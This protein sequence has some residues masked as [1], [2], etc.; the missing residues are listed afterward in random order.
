MPLLR[1]QFATF[2]SPNSDAASPC[3]HIRIIFDIAVRLFCRQEQI[4]YRAIEKIDDWKASIALGASHRKKQHGEDG[5]MG[6]SA[7]PAECRLSPSLR[8]LR[9]FPRGDLP[10]PINRPHTGLDLATR[11]KSSGALSVSKC[12]R[13]RDGPPAGSERWRMCWTFCPPRLPASR[14]AW[15][16]AIARFNVRS[17]SDARTVGG[18]DGSRLTK[19]GLSPGVFCVTVTAAAQKHEPEVATMRGG[20]SRIEN[21]L[22]KTEAPSPRLLFHVRNRPASGVPAS[23]A[24]PEVNLNP[25]RTS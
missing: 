22:L 21:Q 10:R 17:K 3:R 23:G 13:D 16:S 20:E 2:Y 8:A 1:M 19:T 5:S 14:R 18:V 15:Q 9:N 25:C 24:G 7:M 11:D 4:A 6:A 12:G